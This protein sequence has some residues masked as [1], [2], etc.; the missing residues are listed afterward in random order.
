MV[1]LGEVRPEA[2]EVG[3]D[4]RWCCELE[5]FPVGPNRRRRRLA[6]GAVGFEE[7]P[8]A[9]EGDAEVLRRR[10]WLEIGPEEIADALAANRAPEHQEGK[11]AAHP[12]AAQLRAHDLGVAD[13]HPQR[14][15]HLD[16]E[17][18][19]GQSA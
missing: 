18:L 2:L 11:E 5:G 1:G 13:A 15:E 12:T 19:G 9:A 6:C 3:L 7:A 10:L 14:T 4:K 17:R 8:E 16:A